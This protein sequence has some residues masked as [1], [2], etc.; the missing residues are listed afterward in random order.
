VFF[1][2]FFSPF[3]LAESIFEKNIVA[4]QDEEGEESAF[5]SGFPT[6]MAADDGWD[7]VCRLQS[8]WL[9]GP[10]GPTSGWLWGGGVGLLQGTT[11][12]WGAAKAG[13]SEE[14]LLRISW[15]LSSVLQIRIWHFSD[16][17]ILI[18]QYFWRKYLWNVNLYFEKEGQFVFDLMH[19]PLKSWCSPIMY[20]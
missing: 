11:E 12:C 17:V 2:C 13:K 16:L 1:S 20:T 19:M 14:R 10:V 6:L 9:N 15:S 5:H 4:C 8:L 18:L 3:Y 7:A